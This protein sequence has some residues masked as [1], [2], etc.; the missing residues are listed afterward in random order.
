MASSS[1]FL[2]ELS[3]EDA[4]RPSVLTR[5][6]IIGETKGVERVSKADNKSSSSD[7]GRRVVEGA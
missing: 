5:G 2:F 1:F 6:I 4:G 3:V 7:S